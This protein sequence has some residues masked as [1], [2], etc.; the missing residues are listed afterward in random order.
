M[1][2]Q[3]LTLP[4]TALLLALA[5]Q[6]SAAVPEKP[7][8]SEPGKVIEETTAGLHVRQPESEQRWAR[9]LPDTLTLGQEAETAANKLASSAITEAK[10][11]AGLV[12]RYKADIWSQV[13]SAFAGN[14]LDFD[15][16]YL[17]EVAEANRDPRL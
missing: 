14:N 9:Q 10:A 12:E 4:L 3:A 7:Q 5:G 1:A 6:P 17:N 8:A 15:E 11:Q 16:D 2:H 13:K